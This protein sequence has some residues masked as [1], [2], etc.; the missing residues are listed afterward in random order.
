M[1]SKTFYSE[2]Y[3]GVGSGVK[4]T[5]TPALT[6]DRVSQLIGDIGLAVEDSI[7]T[8]DE[9]I[10]ILI[11]TEQELDVTYTNLQQQAS[12]LNVSVAV[13]NSVRS[14]WKNY[15]ETLTP[16]WDDTSA[17]TTID[18]DEF[19]TKI[20]NYLTELA[21]V[22]K[23]VTLEA[24][25]RADIAG[26]LTNEGVPVDRSEVL[27]REGIAAGIEGQGSGATADSL[28]ELNYADFA[29]LQ[30]VKTLSNA[31]R[32][33]VDSLEITY[34]DTASAAQSALDAAASEAAA[35]QAKADAV[36]AKGEAQASAT[37]AA[38]KAIDAAGSASSALT[39]KNDAAASA[40]TAT[41]K[42]QDA[43]S[44]AASAT[45]QAGLAAGSAT[46]AGGS[47]TAAAGS[48]STAATKA[49]EAGNSATAA[50]A[51]KVAAESARDTA[52]QKATAAAQSA[53]SAATSS[54]Q[55][56]Q[57][58]SAAQTAKTAAETARAGAETAQTSAANSATTA[59]GAAA[60]ATTQ[61][62]IAT[63]AKND[64]QAASS[65]AVTARNQAS[66]FADAA[67]VSAA[68]SQASSVSASAARDSAVGAAIAGLP[69]A[70]AAD[71]WTDLGTSGAPADR[72]SL[73]PA[74]VV[75][76]AFVAPIGTVINAGP[77]QRVRWVQ[78]KVI[79]I[80]LRAEVP[81]G[82]PTASVR[83][84]VARFGADH[85][86]LNGNTWLALT[87]VAPGARAEVTVRIS[88]G[89]SVAGATTINPGPEWLSLGVSPNL[90]AAGS[91]GEP[92][93]QMRITAFSVRDI[94]E[95][96]NAASSASAA[97]TSASSAAASETAAGQSAS[98]ASTAKTQAETARGQAQT[99]ATQASNSRDDAAGSAASASSSATNAANSR[100]AAAGSATA[101]AG[102]AS[103]ASTKANEAGV[104][105]AA[106]MASQVS[107]STAASAAQGAAVGA[108]PD[109][110]STTMW[111]NNATTGEPN[112]RPNLT[113]AA[114]VG[115][116]YQPGAGSVAAAGPKG[117]IPWV[118]G[119]IVEV[120]A[121][122]SSPDVAARARVGLELRDTN[123]AR[124]VGPYASPLNL[125]AAGA[126]TTISRRFGLGVAVAGGTR[127]TKGAT[128]W[129]GFYIQ[130]NLNESGAS[131][132]GANQI[133]S[134]LIIRDIT[135]QVGS[136]TAAS[137]SATSAS[138]AAASETAAGQ[139]ASAASGSATNAAT[140]AGQA[141]TYRN[142]ASSSAADA[143]AASVSAGVAASTAQISKVQTFPSRLDTDGSNFTVGANTPVGSIIPLP[144]SRYE[145]VPGFGL[146]GT[147]SDGAII[148]HAA[149][150]A[151]RADR[152]YR[153]RVRVELVASAAQNAR[154]YIRG[155]DGDYNTVTT[156][157]AS[158]WVSLTPGVVTEIS[159]TY[160]S[161]TPPG[162]SSISD[163]TVWTRAGTQSQGA[164][165]GGGYLRVYEIHHE[166]VTESTSAANSAAAAITQAANA[167][168][169]A[170]SAQIS[171]DLAASVGAVRPNLLTNGG[172]ED[173]LVGMTG[174]GTLAI[175]NDPVWGRNIKNVATSSGTHT[176]IWPAIGVR[177][178]ARYTISGDT[179]FFHTG[180]GGYSYL[181]LIFYRADG[182]QALDGPQKNINGPHDFSNAKERLQAHAVTVV[183]P[184]DAVTARARA[185]F[186]NMNAP[187]FM[188]ARRVKVEEGDLPA[189][190][191]TSEASANQI[192]AQLN[193]TADVAADAADRVGSARFSVTG[194]AGGDPFDISLLA[195]PD[196]SAASLTATKIR[197]RN[198]V[199][200]QVVDALT[201]EGGKAKFSGEL[202]VQSGA[203]GERTVITTNAVRV[204]DANNVERVTLGRW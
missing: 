109:L 135:A 9:K 132:P 58:A 104:S 80:R 26:G 133:C 117:L 27:T 110:I 131:E 152:I 17:N 64:A 148:Y 2:F 158:A 63:T 40:T 76:G 143:Q 67:G 99:A 196:G 88:C 169:S 54:T 168:A 51:S 190:A 201:V 122:V 5:T 173:D 90:N 171:A 65:A 43:T 52:D 24:A 44:A 194:G 178:N 128:E 91:A 162:G 29:D 62:G 96:V 123:Y 134:S 85:V 87:P 145:N 32:D 72:A 170:A 193:I 46:S 1:A 108:I 22:Q 121:V 174:S 179:G 49:N 160:G 185:I 130:M 38:Q 150:M 189:T 13:L 203:S 89:V 183:A 154:I 95:S 127:V 48:A 41:T 119:K 195:G 107:A 151:F 86:N 68:A 47:A 35:I 11:P 149:P 100:D 16:E 20:N 181:D 204:F 106:A 75:N 187:T 142:Q 191:F 78:G 153:V 53:S 6:E 102:S 12:S 163:N 182:T 116:T 7:L 103:T 25:K 8:R 77:K 176:I 79:E 125:I 167:S 21:L 83:L 164:V 31:T 74:L 98:A 61:A 113:S 92:G 157:P 37:T 81:A 139:S 73:A 101:A 124:P 3:P 180:S 138:Q 42:A 97:A 118:D 115:A 126:K 192:A 165:P 156:N 144:A 141:L 69:D 166:D 146:V 186:T 112:S 71:L 199:N 10:R 19:R 202:A 30:D 161:P 94:T 114:V 120:T 93:A 57:S 140:S 198:V 105:A 129:V 136:E 111:T 4:G 60:T 70:I 188:G 175:S 23:A 184:A 34:G 50:N 39:S 82:T 172:L 14:I 59:S 56:G 200:G 155:M 197:L 55:A 15:L 45:T 84:G 66:S 177:G 137:A 36:I 18:R 147:A 159:R 28:Q 33:R